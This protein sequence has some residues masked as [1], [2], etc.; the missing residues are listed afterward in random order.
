MGR[1]RDIEPGLWVRQTY[2]GVLLIALVSV[3]SS[4]R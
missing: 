4:V 3:F 2:P 1:T